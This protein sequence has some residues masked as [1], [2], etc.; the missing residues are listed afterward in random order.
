MRATAAGVL[1]LM[2]ST[3]LLLA[4]VGLVRM[5]DTLTRMQP[6]TKGGTLGLALI[7]SGVAV[8][9]G[10]L[11]VGIDASL[12]ILFLFATMPVA[13]HMIGRAAYRRGVPLWER[14]VCDELRPLIERAP[15][16]PLTGPGEP[17]P[18]PRTSQD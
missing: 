13:A 1:L 5:P 18:S 6:A 7:I 9:F 4:A 17:P 2:G 14:S 3:L 16:P 15:E 12:I 10:T 8:H 11:P